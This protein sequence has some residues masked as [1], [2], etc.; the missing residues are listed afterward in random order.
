[1]NPENGIVTQTA[2]C[3]VEEAVSKID[4]RAFAAFLGTRDE[5]FQESINHSD[6]P[7][8]LASVSRAVECGLRW[9][10]LGPADGQGRGVE[11]G[12]SKR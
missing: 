4:E 9:G 5:P 12:E 7:L 8:R 3:T 1:M 2:N 10:G 11:I 6:G